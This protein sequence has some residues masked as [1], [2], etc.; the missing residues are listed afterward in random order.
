LSLTKLV[1]V[2]AVVFFVSSFF[3]SIIFHIQNA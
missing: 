1:V 2:Q 3:L